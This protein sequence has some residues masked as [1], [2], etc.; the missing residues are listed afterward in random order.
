MTIIDHEKNKD[1]KTSYQAAL[2]RC[3]M[4]GFCQDYV[5]P[6]LLLAG[7]TAFHVGL[8]SSLNSVTGSLFTLPSAD[9]ARRVGSRKRVVIIFSVLQSAALVALAI[10]ALNRQMQ[11]VPVIVLAVFSGA[12][13]ALTQPCWFSLI[14]N[15]VDEDRRGVYFG[16]RARN[17]GLLTIGATFTAGC[18]LGFIEK[19]DA[20]AGFIILFA[21]AGISRFMSA[22]F[23]GRVNEPAI[24]Y[25]K[26]HDFSFWA[27]LTSFRRSNFVRFV[28]FMAGMNFSIGLASPYFAVFMLENLSFNYYYYTI[29]NIIA[30]IVLYLVIPRW[31]RHADRTGNLK[32]LSFIAPLF[33]INPILWS[34]S[35]N[36]FVL[37]FAEIISGFLWAG[38]TLASSNFIYDAVTPEKRTRCIAYCGV[39]NAVALGLGTFLGGKI[40]PLLPEV[41]GHR[42][43]CLFLISAALRLISG[44]TLPRMVNEVR[45]VDKIRSHQLLF[46][47]IGI[48]PIA[49]IERKSMQV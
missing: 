25:S 24:E 18:L 43:L 2:F 17:I 20:Y 15:L 7:G 16:W 14:S 21:L 4:I 12:C 26:Q 13:Q 1:L 11:P 44:V 8:T 32:V 40:L 3:L 23:V 19:Y 29:I 41:N 34:I 48:K 47:M 9:I 45:P 30:P 49:G 37:L 33:A 28:F 5:T 31:G 35:Q 38:F 10:L 6:F 46:S 27:F 39:V 42:M 22:V 36:F